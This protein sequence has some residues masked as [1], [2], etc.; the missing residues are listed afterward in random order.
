MKGPR[1]FL[2]VNIVLAVGCIFMNEAIF[3]FIAAFFIFEGLGYYFYARNKKNN[4]KLDSR[5]S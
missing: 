2:V 1:V 5:Q 4:N 3:Y